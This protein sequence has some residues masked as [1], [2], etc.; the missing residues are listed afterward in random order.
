MECNK[1]E[2]I[3]T[4]SLAEAKLQNKDFTG[5]RKMAMKA[6]QLYK[7]LDKIGH[8]LAICNVHCVVE[9]KIHGTERDWYGILQIEET[10]DEATIKTHYRK[11][12]LLLHPDKNKLADAEAAF[13]LIGEAQTVLLDI[14]KK[15]T[16]DMKCKSSVTKLAEGPSNNSKFGAQNGF[17]GSV[18]GSDEDLIII[19]DMKISSSDEEPQIRNGI[20]GSSKVPT[21]RSVR[22]KQQVSYK[23]NRSDDEESKTP[24]KKAKGNG[25]TEW[26][27][28]DPEFNVKCPDP[29]FNVKC[30]DPEF[31]DF[32]KK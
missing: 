5:A 9:S 21:R 17:R 8:I 10:D 2:A 16:Y 13:K 25:S 20:S 18:D 4:K 19:S 22:R 1:E 7:E 6:Q 12:A 28:L 26:K 24:Q 11:L 23:E 14:G 29:E 27:C 31:N 32:K 15:T 3:R 30:P